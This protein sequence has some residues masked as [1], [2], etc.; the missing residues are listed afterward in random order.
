MVF[1]P[2]LDDFNSIM[3]TGFL[4]FE[5]NDPDARKAFTEATGIALLP[6]VRN[7]IEAAIDRA[8]GGND[9]A[10]GRF[11][12]WVTVNVWGLEN[13]PKAY[14]EHLETRAR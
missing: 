4:R 6:P 9:D 8:C 11:V 2:E 5:L 14:R 3:W 12:E 10:L 1:D 7:A 13:A